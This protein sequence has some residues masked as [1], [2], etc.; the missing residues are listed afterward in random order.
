[1]A[2]YKR[3]SSNNPLRQLTKNFIGT[4]IFLG[5]KLF[6]YSKL[7]SAHSKFSLNQKYRW[8]DSFIPEMFT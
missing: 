3:F 6:S 1:M 8:I 4:R 2:K 5:L 7:K